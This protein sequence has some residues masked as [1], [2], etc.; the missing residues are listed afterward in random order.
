MKNEQYKYGTPHTSE[1]AGLWKRSAGDTDAT[2]EEFSTVYDRLSEA[3]WGSK[4]STDYCY[5]RGD[6]YGD[7]TELLEL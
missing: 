7:R 5:F 1:W 6:F 2:V 3:L 4:T